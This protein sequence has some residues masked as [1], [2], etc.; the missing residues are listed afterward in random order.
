M[1]GA[2]DFYNR[3][4]DL[5]QQIA[6]SFGQQKNQEG[7]LCRIEIEK[8]LDWCERNTLSVNKI[9]RYYF[10]LALMYLEGALLK[11]L[12][13]I[14]AYFFNRQNFNPLGLFKN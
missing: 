4:N 1:E 9:E 3:A 7:F 2:E 11:R 14:L 8:A 5:K 10:Y 6:A 12:P 13:H